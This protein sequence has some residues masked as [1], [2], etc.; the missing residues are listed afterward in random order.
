[1]VSVLKHLI[2]ACVVCVAMICTTNAHNQWSSDSVARARVEG[3]FSEAGVDMAL[4]AKDRAEAEMNRS[5]N[6]ADV[7]M[8]EKMAPK[9]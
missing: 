3:E 7:K 8:W 2:W 5:K 1:M 6:E 4:A 9:P